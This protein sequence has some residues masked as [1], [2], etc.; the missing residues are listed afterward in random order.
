MENHEITKDFTIFLK[1][2][3]KLEL[4]PSKIINILLE[5]LSSGTARAQDGGNSIHLWNSQK[6]H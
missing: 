3:E 6:F 4:G 2:T 5:L 1:N